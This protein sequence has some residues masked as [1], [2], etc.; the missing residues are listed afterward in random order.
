MVHEAH[1]PTNYVAGAFIHQKEMWIGEFEATAHELY[2]YAENDVR[3]V[4][5]YAMLLDMIHAQQVYMM[6]WD[7]VQGK[8]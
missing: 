5:E 3:T 6:W 7:S 1:R 8:I 2:A 4:E